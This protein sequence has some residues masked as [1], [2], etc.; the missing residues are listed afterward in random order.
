MRL[1]LITFVTIILTN[2][3]YG[4]NRVNNDSVLYFFQLLVNDYRTINGLKPLSIDKKIKPFTD[5]WAKHMSKVNMVYHGVDT[6]SFSH[7]AK[8]FFPK[9]I[10]CVENC[11]TITTP[12][13]PTDAFINCPIKELIPLLEKTYNGTA[14]QFDYAHFAF[15]LWKNSPD[16]NEALLDPNIVKFYLSSSPSKDLTY[17]EFVGTN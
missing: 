2:S 11:C 4:Q 1:F 3:V 6:N 9:D 15:I 16:H 17:I 10:Y 13:K 5:N 8:N 7:R 12:L 14:T